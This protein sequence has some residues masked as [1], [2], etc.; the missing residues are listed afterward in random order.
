M[1][2]NNSSMSESSWN[3]WLQINYPDTIARTESG[4]YVS[5]HDNP[6]SWGICPAT[7]SEIVWLYQRG[8]L[9]ATQA[10]E[11]FSF[12]DHEAAQMGD[13][14]T[15]I[16]AAGNANAQILRW[17]DFSCL[18]DMVEQHAIESKTYIYNMMGIRDDV[19][20]G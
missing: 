8:F 5:Q 6:R 9:T 12:S 10:R 11:I 16:A 14:K 19:A 1:Q 18:M 4:G 15:W 2:K 7:L 13:I 17:R 3:S 20:S